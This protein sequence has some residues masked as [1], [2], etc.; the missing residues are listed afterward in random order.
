M[1]A[2]AVLV[3]RETKGKE[4]DVRNH[5]ECV[6]INQA[7]CNAQSKQET[8]SMSSSGPSGAGPGRAQGEQ[9]RARSHAGGKTT[10]VGVSMSS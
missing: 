6:D 1:D 3:R 4:I 10:R 7:R 2:I 5:V 9:R 8:M